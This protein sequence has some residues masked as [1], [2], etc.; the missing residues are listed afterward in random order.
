MTET[1][2]DD[3]A[4]S[5]A[6]EPVEDAITLSVLDA[7]Q[8]LI[9]E[10]EG[11]EQ[12]VQQN[13]ARLNDLREKVRGDTTGG[14]I[15]LRHQVES[16]R[17]ERDLALAQIEVLNHDL[18]QA[19]LNEQLA[20]DELGQ[21][22]AQAEQQRRQTAEFQRL[23]GALR[24]EL[25]RKEET[26]R[27]EIERFAGMAKEHAEL[28]EVVQGFEQLETE[29]RQEQEAVRKERERLQSGSGVR[30]PAAASPGFLDFTCKYCGTKL[31]AKE[32]LA[33]LV[34]RCSQ[35]AKMAPVPKPG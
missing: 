7:I 33:G 35:C 24:D 31:Q 32:H 8:Q 1:R 34:T 16:M 19:R 13:F 12:F 20:V 18:R 21:V 11:L 4:D 6:L 25:A 17:V 30:A 3:D 22:R 2:T 14:E 15:E 9:E 23:L 28:M 10:R 27:A 5:A 26:H 29:L